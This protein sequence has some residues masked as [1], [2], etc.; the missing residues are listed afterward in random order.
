MDERLTEGATFTRVTALLEVAE[1]W[2]QLIGW[3]DE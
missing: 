2:Q 1:S 3:C